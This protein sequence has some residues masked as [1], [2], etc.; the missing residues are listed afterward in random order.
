VLAENLVMGLRQSSWWGRHPLIGFVL[1]PVLFYIF[2]WAGCLGALVG[3]DRE[4]R[5]ALV[6]KG[7][8]KISKKEIRL[9]LGDPLTFNVSLLTAGV[10]PAA[11]NSVS[12]K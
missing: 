5:K 3:G 10:L 2:I 11:T 7:V 6:A 9:V 12:Q 1:L 8:A 4:T